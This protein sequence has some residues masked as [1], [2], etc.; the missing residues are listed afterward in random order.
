MNRMGKR[1]YIKFVAQILA[2]TYGNTLKETGTDV[3]MAEEVIKEM[4]EYL[5]FSSIDIPYNEFRKWKKDRKE[6]QT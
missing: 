5:Y 3:L 6:T 4:K 2:R 1:E